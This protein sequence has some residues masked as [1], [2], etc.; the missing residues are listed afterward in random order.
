MIE[1]VNIRGCFISDIVP[2]LIRVK[3]AAYA[4]A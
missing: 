4:L 2:A 3:G 1:Q